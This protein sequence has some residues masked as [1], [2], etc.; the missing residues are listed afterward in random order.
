MARITNA[1]AIILAVYF[2]VAHAHGVITGATGDAGGQGT[3]LAVDASTPRNGIL[4]KPF[5]QDTT[6]FPKD[7]IAGRFSRRAAARS[8]CGKT[9]EVILY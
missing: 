7:G 8:G 3:A 2:P 4:P 6:V 5:E 1:L 9:K